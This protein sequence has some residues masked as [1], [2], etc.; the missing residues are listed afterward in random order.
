MRIDKRVLPHV[1]RLFRGLEAPPR[2]EVRHFQSKHIGMR[3]KNT[4]MRCKNFAC[5]AQG[6]I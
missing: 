4:G 6:C 2:H 5:G 1:F 3:C